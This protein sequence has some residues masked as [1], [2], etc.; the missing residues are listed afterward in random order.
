[1]QIL[2]EVRGL[3]DALA[4][5]EE[6]KNRLVPTVVETLGENL[7]EELEARRGEL[8]VRTGRLR[9]EFEARYREE[10]NAVV[11]SGP[12]YIRFLALGTRAH[13]IRPIH[14]RAL[15]FRDPYTGETVFA[16]RV[17]HPG[18]EPH[19]FFTRS[20][21]GAIL[22]SIEKTAYESLDA[23]VEKAASAAAGT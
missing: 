21:E 3:K 20:L 14:A 1:L 2:I 13:E 19:P 10:E 22:K 15:R 12:P 5:I 9:N 17:W 16:A 18:T 6:F 7:A 4:F 11:I 8:P 23:I